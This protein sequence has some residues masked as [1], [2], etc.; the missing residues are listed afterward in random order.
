MTSFSSSTKQP[1]AEPINLPVTP[2]DYTE[3]AVPERDADL[4]VGGPK[5]RSTRDLIVAIARQSGRMP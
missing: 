5:V 1:S 2:G 3:E 4:T